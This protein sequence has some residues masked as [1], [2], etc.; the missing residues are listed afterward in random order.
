MRGIGAWIIVTLF[1][2]GCARPEGDCGFLSDGY[3]SLSENLAAL[4]DI[5][6]EALPANARLTVERCYPSHPYDDYLGP[7][8]FVGAKRAA[9]GNIYLVYEPTG[10]TDVQLVFEVGRDQ[11][12]LKAFQYSTL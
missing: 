6:S 4:A 10:I 3:T 11:R 2:S 1:A 12:P 5:R 8:R 7:F 9:N